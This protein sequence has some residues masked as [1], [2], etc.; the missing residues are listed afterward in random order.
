[1]TTAAQL[2][3]HRLA[4]RGLLG[5][6]LHGLDAGGEP[7]HRRVRQRGIRLGEIGQRIERRLDVAGGC[8]LAREIARLAPQCIGF[9][10]EHRRQQAQQRP[11]ALHVL[12]VFM[13][14]DSVAPRAVVER[15]ARLA[16]N[17]PGNGGE[18]RAGPDPY[19]WHAVHALG[20]PFPAVEQI[21]AGLGKE[22]FPTAGAIAT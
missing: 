6:H 21:P 14:G 17:L 15:I 16:E 20:P 10:A 4:Q 1:V 7:R 19:G 2:C 22:P 9:R 8:K 13:D 18:R 12:A 5:V 3:A 11:P